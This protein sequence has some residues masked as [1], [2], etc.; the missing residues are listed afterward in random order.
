MAAHAE[1]CSRGCG[2]MAIVAECNPDAVCFVCA[3]KEIWY[4]W[5]SRRQKKT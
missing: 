5:R 4:E 1:D 2:R 3:I